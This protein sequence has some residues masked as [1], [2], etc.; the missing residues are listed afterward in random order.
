MNKCVVCEQ[1][2]EKL[3]Y[4]GET[5][6]LIFEKAQKH[7]KDALYL[8]EESHIVDHLVDK[9]PEARKSRDFFRIKVL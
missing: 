7:H 5:S 6:K 3:H 2:G 4:I 1:K 8:P 9:H